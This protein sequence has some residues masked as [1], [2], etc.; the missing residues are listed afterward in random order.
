MTQ[1]VRQDYTVAYLVVE[2]GG[3]VFLI[4]FSYCTIILPVAKELQQLNFNI[5][6]TV[7]TI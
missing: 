3:S 2:G 6:N 1:A 7:L 5:F 4:I